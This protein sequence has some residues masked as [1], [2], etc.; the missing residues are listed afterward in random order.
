MCQCRVATISGKLPLHLAMR[1]SDPC[2]DIVKELVEVTDGLLIDLL[3][4]LTS[5]LL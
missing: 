2:N 5:G 3:F 4:D 1:H